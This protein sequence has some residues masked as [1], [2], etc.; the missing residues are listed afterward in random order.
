MLTRTQNSQ[1]SNHSINEE[2][3]SRTCDADNLSPKDTSSLSPAGI[4]QTTVDEAE[5][6]SEERARV[7]VL[8]LE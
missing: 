3:L 6:L 2:M 8:A 7:S 1:E 5:H 4:N